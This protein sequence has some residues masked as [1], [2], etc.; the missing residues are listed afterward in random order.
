MRAMHQ[1]VKFGIILTHFWRGN[2]GKENTG[3]NVPCIPWI[4]VLQLPCSSVATDPVV[5]GMLQTQM[6]IQLTH[7]PFRRNQLWLPFINN[8]SNMIIFFKKC[9]NRPRSPLQPSVQKKN[10]RNQHNSN[11]YHH[12]NTLLHQYYMN[13]LIPYSRCARQ[14]QTVKKDAL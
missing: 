9:C 13:Y 8:Q 5:W 14:C 7:D 3:E 6:K 4:F 12:L 1:I 2:W 11:P 10:M